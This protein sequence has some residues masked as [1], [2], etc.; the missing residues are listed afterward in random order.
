MLNNNHKV[1]NMNV[2]ATLKLNNGRIMSDKQP[3]IDTNWLQHEA[4]K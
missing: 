3:Q 2:Q 4:Y 1:Q